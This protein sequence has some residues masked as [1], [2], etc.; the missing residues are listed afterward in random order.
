MNT[1]SAV[2]LLTDGQDPA[3]LEKLRR[4]GAFKRLRDGNAAGAGGATMFTFGFGSGEWG[5]GEGGWGGKGGRDEA[6]LGHR[7]SEV[8]L[9]ATEWERDARE[10]QALRV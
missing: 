3:A 4:A 1:V 8:Q 7:A 9:I 10:G 5:G 2:L 6:K